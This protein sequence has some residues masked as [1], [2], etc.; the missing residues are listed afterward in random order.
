M[1]HQLIALVLPSLFAAMPAQA[2][3]W[4]YG[5]YVDHNHWRVAH[6][7]SSV[8]KTGYDQYSVNAFAISLRQSGAGR[9]VQLNIVCP[10]LNNVG[11]FAG[12]STT[13]GTWKI[14]DRAGAVVRSGQGIAGNAWIDDDE[15]GS[16]LFR[17]VKSA[18]CPAVAQKFKINRTTITEAFPFP[19]MQAEAGR[20]RRDAISESLTKIYAG[21]IEK[22]RIEVV[23]NGERLRP[24]RIVV[25]NCVTTL[26][27]ANRPDLPVGWSW[28]QKASF[29]QKDRDFTM[30]F[31]GLGVA[32]VYH[33]TKDEMAYVKNSGPRFHPELK[34]VVDFNR[35]VGNLC[36]P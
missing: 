5:T 35:I 7:Q 16:S 9:W 14:Y 33:A 34:Y 1:R 26:S 4:I 21:H 19:Q 29:S 17:Y 24:V 28:M 11:D 18:V 12:G 30:Q 6:D 27:F 25:A 15:E 13:I 8:R 32:I 22:K 10:Q 23:R 36:A 2:Q 20:K 31:G 3:T